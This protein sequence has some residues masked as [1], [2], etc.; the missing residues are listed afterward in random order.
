MTFSLILKQFFEPLSLLGLWLKG[1]IL[2]VVAVILNIHP[3]QPTWAILMTLFAAFF[4]VPIGFQEVRKRQSVIAIPDTMLIV[5]LPV[6]IMAAVGCCLPQSIWAGILVVPYFMW[7][8][9]MVVKTIK[10]RFD[11]PYL[12]HLFAWG[13]LSV[14]TMWLVIDRLGYQPFGFSSWIL[15]LTATHFHYAGFS[16]ILSLSLFLY[17][18][19][20]HRLANALSIAV[21]GGIVLT[22]T[23]ITL[24]QVMHI[25]IVETVSGIFM[26]IVGAACGWLFFYNAIYQTKPTQYLWRV[27]GLC[28]MTAMVLAFLYASRSLWIISFLDIPFMQ[29]VHGTTNALG[30]GRKK[31][32]KLSILLRINFLLFLQNRRQKT[33]L[34][35]RYPLL[36]F[37]HFLR[38][39]FYPNL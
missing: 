26:S 16:L 33:T 15:L 9:I 10:W 31:Y 7:S 5:H 3:M 24:N 13:I 6:V 28:L 29:A 38:H 20:R 30:F 35:C 27:G 22:A 14:A 37:A 32:I 36:L 2:L 39:L 19:P 11:L 34:D 18:N 12:M 8:A 21:I 1:A 23:G 17:K 25:H 4:L